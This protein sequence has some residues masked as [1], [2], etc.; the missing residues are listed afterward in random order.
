M[1]NLQTPLNPQAPRATST[2]IPGQPL[3]S[4]GMPT[5]QNPQVMPGQA[6]ATPE[7]RQQLVELMEA[8]K[9]K[10]ANIRSLEFSGANSRESARMDALR[11][12]FSMMQSAGVDLTSPDSVHEF[13]EKV[14]TANPNL[15]Q[16]VEFAIDKLLGDDSMVASDTTNNE[17]L[18]ENIRGPFSGQEGMA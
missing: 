11:Q 14:R 10:M 8:T 12:L 4:Q 15:A 2:P 1:D 16:D 13:L 3:Q 18:P 17:T 6:F 9:G 7:E 5:G